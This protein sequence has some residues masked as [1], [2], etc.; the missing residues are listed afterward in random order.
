[1]SNQAFAY[2]VIGGIFFGA[3]PYLIRMSHLHWTIAGFLLQIG[4][5]FVFGPLFMKNQEH[6]PIVLGT[7]IV[8]ALAAGAMNGLGH[9]FF[10]PLLARKDVSIG[11]LIVV[12][13]VTQ[14][15]LTALVDRFA[16]GEPLTP[17]KLAGM[18]TAILTA[19]LVKW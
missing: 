12:L 13:V 6:R 4:T 19:Y 9:R 14:I 8:L 10:Q 18:G 5:L 16:N 3:Y 1:M 15:V 2:A 11:Q 17:R 7:W